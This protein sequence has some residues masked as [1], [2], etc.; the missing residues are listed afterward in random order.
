MFTVEFRLVKAL[1]L[2]ELNTLF[3][4]ADHFLTGPELQSLGLAGLDARRNPAFFQT[5]KA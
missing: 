5:V 4:D 1:L 3:T 2:Q